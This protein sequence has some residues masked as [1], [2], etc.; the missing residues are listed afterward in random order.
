MT[1]DT[2]FASNEALWM[3]PAPEFLSWLAGDKPCI[4][5]DETIHGSVET[6]GVMKLMRQ[7]RLHGFFFGL[8]IFVG[9]LAWKSATSLAPG[10]ETLERGLIQEGDLA[11]AGEDS[12]RGLVNLLRRNLPARHLI[13]QCLSA[14]RSASAITGV[15]TE[16]TGQKAAID[17]ILALHENRPKEMSP[18]DAYFRISHIL[19]HPDDYRGVGRE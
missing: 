3:E 10:S 6:G 17:A 13:A 18:T 4:V 9:L 19:A 16:T 15:R 14:H 12:S 1:S 7:F 11:V 8:A 2:F 5:F